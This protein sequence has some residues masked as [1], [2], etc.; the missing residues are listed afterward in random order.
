MRSTSIKIKDGAGFHELNVHFLD[1]SDHDKRYK[2]S[3]LGN[4]I[5]VPVLICRFL[6]NYDKK[7]AHFVLK[8]RVNKI[9]C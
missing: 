9:R 6:T 4:K 5:K 1:I 8:K 3:Y 7:Y 2:I